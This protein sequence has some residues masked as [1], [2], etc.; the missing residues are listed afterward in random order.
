MKREADDYYSVTAE[1][2]SGSGPFFFSDVAA[3]IRVE[4]DKPAT[5]TS[6]KY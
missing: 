1:P 3:V 2:R 4:M 6:P 5:K